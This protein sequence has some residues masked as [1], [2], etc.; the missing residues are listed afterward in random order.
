MIRIICVGKIK[1]QFLK[2]GINEYLKRM[3]AFDKVEIIELK[4]ITNKSKDETI[5]LESEAIKNTI[6][7]KGYSILLDIKGEMIDSVDLSKMIQKIYAYS[8]STI[9]FII[10]G[11]YGVSEE[12]KNVCNYRLSFSKMTFPH[13][14]MRLILC[15]QI[16]RAFTILN[17][18]EYHK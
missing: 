15:E 10:G 14:L 4:E 11:S 16:Y 1:E 12:L 13:Q 3:K 17:N 18:Q 7:N 2:D 5:V 6:L 8:S 9:N